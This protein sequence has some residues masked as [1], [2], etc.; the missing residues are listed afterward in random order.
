MSQFVT[1]S[2]PIKILE[3]YLDA[4]GHVNNAAYISIFEAARWEI[5]TSAGC[6]LDFIKETGIGPVILE[7]QTKFI[8]ELRL[9]QEVVIESKIEFWR[10]KIGVMSQVIVDKDRN[11][12]CEAK[13]TMG[14]FDLS[15][16]K[17]VRADERWAKALGVQFQD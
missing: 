11:V 12:Y 13:F 6:G 5:I 16:R 2:H 7:I 4:Y 15:A 8:K 9:R 17:L 10:G 3:A 1:Y 14:L